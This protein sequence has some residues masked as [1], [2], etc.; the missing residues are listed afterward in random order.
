MV[1][2][3]PTFSHEHVIS[4]AVH[5]MMDKIYYV[6]VFGGKSVVETKV[7]E[8]TRAPFFKYITDFRTAPGA[9]EKFAEAWKAFVRA[10]PPASDDTRAGSVDKDLLD[11]F[12]LNNDDG[13]PAVHGPPADRDATP[14]A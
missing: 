7:P 2:G 4:D 1:A 13:D 12:G 5:M 11:I 6:A 10:S 8:S 9:R 14:P 3:E